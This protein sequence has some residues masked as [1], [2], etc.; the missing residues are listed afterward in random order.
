MFSIESSWLKNGWRWTTHS[1][2]KLKVAD[3]KQS[4]QEFSLSSSPAHYSC[5][6]LILFP[7]NLNV[8]HNTHTQL[9]SMHLNYISHSCMKFVIY[10]FP[11]HLSIQLA[12]H[13]FFSSL[14]SSRLHRNQHIIQLLNTLNVILTILLTI[15]LF[16]LL[17][18]LQ[19]KCAT[20]D[21]L[22]VLLWINKFIIN[23]TWNE[24]WA[25]NN[26]TSIEYIFFFL[27][28]FSLFHLQMVKKC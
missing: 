2:N 5:S 13:Y 24:C 10:L 4:L 19:Y 18:Q 28:L 9:H 26:N 11:S 1:G 14:T 20:D 23:V 6:H 25:H 3:L 17:Q 15:Y 12:S 22:S 16:N 7:S 27:L 8:N 21:I